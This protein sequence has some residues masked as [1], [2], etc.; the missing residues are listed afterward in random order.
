MNIHGLSK[1]LRQEW[2]L[3]LICVVSS[4]LLVFLFLY[5]NTR[6]IFSCRAE[7]QSQQALLSSRLTPKAQVL[8]ETSPEEMDELL[9]LLETVIPSFPQEELFLATLENIATSSGVVLEDLEFSQDV[10]KIEDQQE[11]EVSMN[12]SVKGGFSQVVSF[13]INLENARRVVRV[14]N[15]E[16]SGSGGEVSCSA[17]VEA[18]YRSIP[19]YL[20]RTEE[21]I[22]ELSSKDQETLA[23]ARKLV[24]FTPT[25]REEGEGVGVGKTDP[26]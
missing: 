11:G 5:P 7:I 4:V 6:N 2:L 25:V 24:N 10:K 12:I 18:P 1:I 20:G 3:P 19:T 8:A 22:E 9:N 14:T 23:L 13:F 17:Q 26:F 21:P 15:I 16:I